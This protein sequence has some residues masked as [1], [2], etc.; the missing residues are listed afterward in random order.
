VAYNSFEK[1]LIRQNVKEEI[2][3]ACILG[4]YI[5]ED[6][7]GLKIVNNINLIKNVYLESA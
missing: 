1:W 7:N 5:C 6:K 2:R 3:E 4:F